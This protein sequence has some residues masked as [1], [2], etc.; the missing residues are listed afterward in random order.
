MAGP[1][2]SYRLPDDFDASGRVV[3]LGSSLG[4]S[5]LMWARALPYFSADIQ[6]VTWDLPG[7]GDSDVA[8]TGFTLREIADELVRIADNLGVEKFD[9]A[10]VS[11]SGAIALELGIHHGDR[12]GSTAVMFS[13]AKLGTNESWADR[14]ATVREHGTAA[15]VT[16]L[17]PR[18]FSPKFI[19]EDGPWVETLMDILLDVDAESYA[20]CCEALSAYDVR[21][22][23][24]EV[25]VPT[26]V[27]AG[28]HDPSISAD[29]VREL[30]AG[31]PNAKLFVVEGGRHLAVVDFPH[32]VGAALNTFWSSIH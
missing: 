17:P 10:G 27:I 6:P 19:A 29:A 20:K 14:C 4:S 24:T 22:Q 1:E 9:Y 32:E 26:L 23:L 13:A 2:I 18:W 8:T 11:I 15:M 30:M 16:D 7:H 31:L 3:F 12:L 21:E 25:T 28:D 5:S